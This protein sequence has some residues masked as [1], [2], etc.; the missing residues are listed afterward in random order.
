MPQ[1]LFEKL[2]ALNIDT[3]LIGLEKFID[4]N[5]F[6]I[7]IGAEIFAGLGIDGVQFC[8][9]N[10]FHDMIFSISP[11]AL[12]NKYVN[13]LAYNFEDFLGLIITCKNA[14]PLEQIYWN[15][16]DNFNDF[17]K[18]DI[19]ENVLDGQESILQIVQTEL[20]ILPVSNPYSYV[21]KIQ[22]EFDYSL[23][24]YSDEFYEIT[25]LEKGTP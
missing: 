13:P 1:P 22:S 15:T 21:K 20:K 12:H 2:K 5:Y 9:I 18:K 3:S 25:G 4:W 19:K 6:C 24:K 23:I 11:E 14:N 17:L 10:G 16:E 7:P 8:T